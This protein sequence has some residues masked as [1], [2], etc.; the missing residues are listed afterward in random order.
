MATV[1][2][3]AG[4]VEISG[5][6]MLGPTSTITPTRPRSELSQETEKRYPIPASQWFVFDSGQPLPST[7]ASDDLGITVGTHGTGTPVLSAGDVKNTSSTRKARAMVALPPEYV[8]G[9]TVKIVVSAGVKTT[10]AS[11]SVTV[12]FQAY[13]TDRLRI[14]GHFD[15][16]RARRRARYP[17]LDRL[18]RFAHGDRGNSGR[19]GRFALRHQGLNLESGRLFRIVIVYK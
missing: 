4:D 3:I 12:D 15:F 5:N 19:D 7:A 8:A 18:Q 9:E 13:K 17:H 14:H 1:Q 6:L 11:V 16:A 10:V 2:R